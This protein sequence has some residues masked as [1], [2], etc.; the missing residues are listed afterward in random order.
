VININY[1]YFIDDG[2]SNL[3]QLSLWYKENKK[4]VEI[5]KKY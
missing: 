5:N 4:I 2:I 3:D 1:R